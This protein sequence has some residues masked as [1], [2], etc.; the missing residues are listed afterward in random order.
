V[1]L[2]IVGILTLILCR[3]QV[4]VLTSL[5]VLVTF[6]LFGTILTFILYSY[7]SYV[8]SLTLTDCLVMTSPFCYREEK[9]LLI[10]IADL[11]HLFLTF[12]IIIV[13]LII[14]RNTHRPP[15]TPVTSTAI[16]YTPQTQS[17]PITFQNSCATAINSPD[18]A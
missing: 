11:I 13:N 7:F 18:C 6:Q 5:F 10:I 9:I 14:I 17:M 3:Q 1:F 12:C 15:I 2:V 4:Y 16:I 8:I